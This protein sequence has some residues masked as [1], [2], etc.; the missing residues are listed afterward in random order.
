MR[1]SD[2]LYGKVKPQLKSWAKEIRELKN[3]RK[4]D[5][6]DGRALWDIEYDIAKLKYEFRHHHIAY[7]LMRGRDRIEIEQPRDDHL[8][9]ENKIEVILKNW[10]VEIDEDVRLS[11]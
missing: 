1:K 11:A 6:R 9:N 2:L 5:K 7:C 8:P 3:S 10:E 4:Q